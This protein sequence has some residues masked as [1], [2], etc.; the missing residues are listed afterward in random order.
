[1][2]IVHLLSKLQNY[3]FRVNNRYCGVGCLILLKASYFTTTATAIVVPPVVKTRNRKN[4]LWSAVRKPDTKYLSNSSIYA[5][6]WFK[7][8]IARLL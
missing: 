6:I 2:T 1:M 4:K 3:V 5:Q 7:F 8:S